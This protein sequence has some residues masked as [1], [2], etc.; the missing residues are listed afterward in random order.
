M[1][2]RGQ[3]TYVEAA[4]RAEDGSLRRIDPTAYPDIAGETQIVWA[5]AFELPLAS[6]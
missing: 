6:G 1:S 3:L 4:E 5:K 2:G